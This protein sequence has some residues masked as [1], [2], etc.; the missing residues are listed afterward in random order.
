LHEHNPYEAPTAAVRSSLPGEQANPRAGA[1]TY[2]AWIFVFAINMALPLLFSAP[3]T[4]QHGR[5]GMAVAAVLLLVLGCYICAANRKLAMALLAGGAVVALAQLFPIIHIIAGMIGMTVG[6][7]VGHATL[8]S[9]DGPSR[10]TSES[11]GFIVTFVTGGILM[12]G[13]LF[14]GVLLRFVTSFRSTTTLSS[15][16]NQVQIG[17]QHGAQDR[18]A[19]RA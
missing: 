6:Q 19:E 18:D 12:A 11:G 13:S 16:P 4:E 2:I 17:A 14:I 15:T 5:L 7:A 8:D 10:I 3:M 1:L 9:D